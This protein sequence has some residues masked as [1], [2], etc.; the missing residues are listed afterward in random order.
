M[1]E[2]SNIYKSFRQQ[3]VLDGVNLVVEAQ[4]NLIILGRSGTGKSV[5]LKL[6]IGLLKPD[7]GTIKVFDQEITAINR[8]ALNQVRKRMGFLFQDAALYDSMTVR[9]NVAFPLH[10]HTEMSEA[11]INEV[12]INKLAQVGLKDYADKMPAE[13]SGGMRKRA[14]LA[15]ALALD[16]TVMLYDEPTAGLDPITAREIDELIL[17]LKESGVTSITV[18]HEIVSARN[19]GDQFAVLHEGAVIE[20]GSFE[21]LQESNNQFVRQFVAN[22]FADV[23]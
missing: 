12:A 20:K 16:P 6:I 14:G 19:V 18:T 7:R 11:E 22:A 9:E 1:I 23:H 3:R 8:E 13:L 15:R 10:R 17:Q 21:Q 2:V 5:L 4:Q